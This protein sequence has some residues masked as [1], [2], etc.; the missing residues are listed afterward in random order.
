MTFV[1][2]IVPNDLVPRYTII[3]KYRDTTTY[4]CIH[5]RV[6]FLPSLAPQ[7][8]TNIALLLMRNS[9]CFLIPVM[10]SSICGHES[11]LRQCCVNFCWMKML[12]NGCP[13]GK[14]LSIYPRSAIS[15]LSWEHVDWIFLVSILEHT[16]HTA[17]DTIWFA[18][19]LMVCI[20][21]YCGVTW[22]IMMYC[23]VD[24]RYSN[25]YGQQFAYIGYSWW[26]KL[27][28]KTKHTISS[29]VICPLK[30]SMLRS[31]AGYD[32]MLP[33]FYNKSRNTVLL[34]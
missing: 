11:F 17:Y 3:P 8:L 14:H 6:T 4:I 34:C 27:Y 20:V 5:L 33:I 9:P 22:R 25:I 15:I 19:S 7:L 29:P 12:G 16:T 1:S 18:A 21:M 23:I 10:L 31:H 30:N 26:N 28:Y 13:A 32:I 24:I 2:C